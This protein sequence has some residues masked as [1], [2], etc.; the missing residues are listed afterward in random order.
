MITGTGHIKSLGHISLQLTMV[1]ELEGSITSHL[2]A[3]FRY[4]LLNELELVNVYTVFYLRRN[5]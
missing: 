4:V 5:S 2:K 1:T 3:I